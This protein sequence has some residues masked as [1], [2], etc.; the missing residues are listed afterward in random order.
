MTDRWTIDPAQAEAAIERLRAAKRILMPT[1]QN[2]DADGLGT[3][4][5]L[6]HALKHFGVQADVLLSDMAPPATGHGATD[7][8]RSMA[9]AE[10]GLALAD[11]LLRPGGAFLVKL[12]QGGGEVGYE[13]ALRAKFDAVRRMKPSASRSESR[14]IYLLGTGFRGPSVR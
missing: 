12:L 10:A 11:D 6:K 1:H 3:P 9:L 14:E 8:L 13:R 2:V 4:L 5:A 7:H